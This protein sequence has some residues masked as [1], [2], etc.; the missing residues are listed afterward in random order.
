MQCPECDIAMKEFLVGEEPIKECP[1][2]RGLWFEPGQLENVKDEVL[3]DMGW[4]D[5]AALKEQF[6]FKAYTDKLFCPK[7]RDNVLTKIQDRK[8]RAEFFVCSQCKGT[9]LATGQFLN[10]VNILLNEANKKS[11]PELA[12]ISLQQ[13]KDLLTSPDSD[14]A[15]W[16]GLKTVLAL[17]K[18]RIF[19]ENPKLKSIIGGLQKSLPL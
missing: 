16:H 2:C 19:V 18:R 13:A 12:R 7:C 14:I 1:R 5:V 10:L 11:A 15:E 3:P 9:W 6:D 17:L 4:L 8:T